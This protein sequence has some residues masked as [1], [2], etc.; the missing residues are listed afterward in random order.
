M[1][2]FFLAGC[3][4]LSEVYPNPVGAESG[5]GSAGDCREFVEL[6]NACS[7]AVDVSGYRLAD[8]AETDSLIPF[9]DTT[10]RRLHDVVLGTTVIPPRSFA[11]ILDPEYATA[12]CQVHPLLPV[13]AGVVVLGVL[14]TD[15]GNGLSSVDTLRLLAPTG[16]V[17]RV[18]PLDVPEGRSLERWSY[19]ET[20]WMISDSLSP[21]GWNTVSRE[22]DP[23]IVDFSV[24]LY[25]QVRLVERGFTAGTA[26][27]VLRVDGAVLAEDSVALVP[28]DT[29]TVSLPL[30]EVHPWAA[31]EIGVSMA[32]EARSKTVYF[33]SATQGVRISEILPDGTVEWVELANLTPD[34]VDLAGAVLR[35]RSGVTSG[36]FPS[37]RLPPSGVVVITGDTTA[38]RNR[39]G[40]VPVLAPEGGKMPVLNN[41]S[42]ALTLVF[43]GGVQMDSLGYEGAPGYD[44][45]LVRT[46]P[47]APA[48]PGFF[49]PEASPTPGVYTPVPLPVP[50][51]LELS[52]RVF[53]PPR[54]AL[55]I[56]FALPAGEALKRVVVFNDRGIPV[57]TLFSGSGASS[58][59]LVWDGRGEGGRELPA[60]LYLVLVEGTSTRLRKV[61]GLWIR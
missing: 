2:L 15:I 60:G 28:L 49:R 14:D 25:L 1:I 34:T 56:R 54:E 42:E 8:N 47:T 16:E 13:E 41:T 46:S 57:R 35:D 23:V 61:V 40:D 30:G 38:F 10:L 32:G 3:L 43:P 58:G 53:H 33:P 26:R 48:P 21:G 4:V 39:W 36:T 9:P 19:D 44:Q 17:D 31:G 18:G 7:L 51:N 5:A 45:S 11:L 22:V 24:G 55:E 52:A 50:G 6:F 29:V 12:A 59:V 20:L 27:V 37:Y